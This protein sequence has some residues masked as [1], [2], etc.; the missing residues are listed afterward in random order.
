MYT[1][2][3]PQTYEHAYTNTSQ[4]Q[5]HEGE[6]ELIFFLKITISSEAGTLTHPGHVSHCLGWFLGT[7]AITASPAMHVIGADSLG[8]RRASSRDPGCQEEEH[9]R[10]GG[11]C[12][13]R[14]N[15]VPG[16]G[17]SPGRLW[18]SGNEGSWEEGTPV[19]G[20]QI[21]LGESFIISWLLLAINKGSK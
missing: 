13:G 3:G 8:R 12:V 14:K 1:H 4:T 11:E 15:S 2:V 17:D 7:C 21:H 10:P 6:K 16:P 20:L 5:T 19:K 9:T 18:V